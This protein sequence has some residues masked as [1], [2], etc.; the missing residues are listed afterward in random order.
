[1][2]S[3]LSSLVDNLSDVYDKECIRC[4]E[5]K[6][7][8]VNCG[9]VRFKNGRLNYKCKECKKSCTKVINE[10]S[11]NFPTLYKYCNADLNKFFL[12][13]RKCI[14]PYKYIDNWERFDENTIPP[15]EAFYSKLNLEISQIKTMSMLKRYGNYLK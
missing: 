2:Q 6:K 1:M 9:F 7:I 13:L 14:Y 4:K 3:S 12:L 15:R 8:S 11:K 10:S 5:R